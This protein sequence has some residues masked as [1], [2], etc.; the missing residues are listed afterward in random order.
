MPTAPY[1][2]VTRAQMLQELLNRLYDPTGVFWSAAFDGELD[3][4][5]NEALRTWNALTSYWRDDFVFTPS[6]AGIRWYDIPSL[7]NTLRPYVFLDTNIY[8]EMQWMLL[9]PATG[10]NPWTGSSQ[11][12]A[13]DFLNAVQRRR[14]EVLSVTGCT[15]ARVN[16]NGPRTVPAVAGRITLPD[17]V[18][19]IRR[20]AYLPAVGLPSTV[21]PEDTWGEMAFQPRYLQLPAGT[22]DTY[23]Q[24]TQPPISFDTNRPPGSAGVYELLTIESGPPMSVTVPSKLNIPDDWVHVVKWGALDD[25]LSRESN[26]KDSLRAQYCEGRYRMGLRLLQNASALL[27]VRVNNVPIQI[28]SINAADKY[29][30]TWQAQPNG[31]PTAAYYSGLNWLALSPAPESTNYSITL[32]VVENAPVNN[33]PGSQVQMGRDVYD[34]VLDYAQHLA[35]FKMGGAEFLATLPL[36]QRFMKQ[37]SIYSS[38]LSEIAEYTSAILGLAS[39]EKDMNPVTTPT[40]DTGAADAA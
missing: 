33:A 21:W 20:M 19:D 36:F 28:D 37:A 10:I 40:A 39:R 7:P 9:E 25:L 38:K 1:S 34:A 18:I 2:Y 27:G 17:T 32:T 22:P 15:I 30:A 26:A 14:D 29:Q 8:F 35:A 31:P 13:D 5:I 4:Y 12:T 3:E 23:L 6:F 24:S 16:P 11:F